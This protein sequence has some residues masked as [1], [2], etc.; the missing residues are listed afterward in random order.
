MGNSKDANRTGGRNTGRDGHHP[1][2]P[3]AEKTRLKV[4]K[5]GV[6]DTVAGPIGPAGPADH[7]STDRGESPPVQIAGNV[8]LL[9]YADIELDP[10]GY[11]VRRAGREI[12]LCPIEF[13]LLRHLLENPRQVFSRDDLIGAGWRKNVHVGPRTVD[14]HVGQLRRALGA[15]SEDDLIRTVRS[16]GYVLAEPDDA[17]DYH[18]PGVAVVGHA[19]GGPSTD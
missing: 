12:H 2:R 17:L 8:S 7:T 14:V 3:G 6:D 9:T 4:L 11:R 15:K 16:V 5:S 10:D 18:G 19:D 1:C 13:R